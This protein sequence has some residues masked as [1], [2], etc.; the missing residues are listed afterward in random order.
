MKGI[1]MVPH[2]DTP[3]KPPRTIPVAALERPFPD[4]D[5]APGPAICPTCGKPL[6]DVRT[7]GLLDY[8]LLAKDVL[9]DLQAAL[10]EE[11]RL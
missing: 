8:V 10:E 11:G 3:H 1:P 9:A 5:P 4:N 7:S 2:D 6:F